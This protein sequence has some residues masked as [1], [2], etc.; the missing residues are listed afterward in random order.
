MKRMNSKGYTFVELLGVIIV[1]IIVI[2]PIL[3]FLNNLQDKSM[4][5]HTLSQMNIIATS[6]IERAKCDIKQDALDDA[7]IFARDTSGG[8]IQ[9]SDYGRYSIP[10]EFY[11]SLA[12]N[13]V[14]GLD[15]ANELNLVEVEVVVYSD[16]LP[17][18][19]TV[20]LKTLVNYD[21]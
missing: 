5:S 14:S 10:N 18:D 13:P 6:I 3:N 9:S 2:T 21:E 8:Y 19:K 1:I 7:D 16:N 11:A 20:K 12:I 17:N 4:E 15:P